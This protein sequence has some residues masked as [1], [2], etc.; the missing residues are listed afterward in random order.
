[1]SSLYSGVYDGAAVRIQSVFRRHKA[2][3]TLKNAKEMF[4][5]IHDEIEKELGLSSKYVY[6]EVFFVK[7]TVFS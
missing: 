4:M 5:R 7:V 2:Q 3:L 1:M 6:I